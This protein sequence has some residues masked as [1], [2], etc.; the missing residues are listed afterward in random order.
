VAKEG[1]G[2]GGSVQDERAA[3]YGLLPNFCS[4]SPPSFPLRSPSLP[5]SPHHLL[6]PPLPWRLSLPA[7]S[8]PRQLAKR[9]HLP[10]R[11][12][13]IWFQ[14]C[15]VCPCTR[16]R[17]DGRGSGAKHTLKEGSSSHGALHGLSLWFPMLIP[18]TPHG[19]PLA[20]L[21]WVSKLRCRLARPGA[22]LHATHAHRG[23]AVAHFAMTCLSP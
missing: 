6:P 14:V 15:D 21:W 2:R 18:P 7:F 23:A 22:S 19:I 17:W 9:I 1:N 13:A 11:S 5:P 8:S 10:E 3:E 16:A 20:S 4:A 12:I